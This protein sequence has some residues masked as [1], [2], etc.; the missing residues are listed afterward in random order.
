MRVSWCFG[1]ILCAFVCTP[2]LAQESREAYLAG[3]RA[4]VKNSAD[5]QT[6]SRQHAE[7]E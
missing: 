1:L 3:L 4:A 7:Q 2:V 5:S 6:E